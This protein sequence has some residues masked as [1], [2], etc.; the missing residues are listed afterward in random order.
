MH[1][2]DLSDALASVLVLKYLLEGHCEYACD[3][4]RAALESEG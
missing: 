1:P 3:F 4:E 2:C